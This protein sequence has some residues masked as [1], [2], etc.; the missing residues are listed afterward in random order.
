MYLIWTENG[1]K[2][3]KEY[4]TVCDYTVGENSKEST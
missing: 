2:D 4:P 1:I 3:A